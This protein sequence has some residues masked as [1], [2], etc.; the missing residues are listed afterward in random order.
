MRSILFGFAA[1]IVLAACSA[2]AEPD[3]PGHGDVEHSASSGPVLAELFTSQGCSSCPPAEAFF[4]TLAEREDLAV[5]VWHVDVWDTLVHGGS[6][7]KDPYSDPAFT[8]RIRNYNRVIRGTGRIFT[9]QAIIGGETSVIGSRKDQIQDAIILAAE[10]TVKVSIDE[11][12]A[13]LS[14][15]ES[16]EAE[17]IY[18]RLLKE[19]Q[20]DV[21][22][23]ENKGRQL[24]GKNI[25]L[26]GRMLGVWEG[27]QTSFDLPDLADN[28]TC[29]VIVQTPRSGPV[30]GTGM[31]S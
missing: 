14:G 30:L 20:T 8:A 11:G 15:A 21:T 17:V 19:H 23:G 22:G 5:I 18:V 16:Q 10:P 26:E 4:E 29:A 27:K 9:P 13:T 1:A 28:E 24:S 2:Q 31:C 7:W 12:V 25:A 6:S 3:H